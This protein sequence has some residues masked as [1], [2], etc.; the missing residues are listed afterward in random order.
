MRDLIVTGVF[1]IIGVILGGIMSLVTVIYTQ[2][3]TYSKDV[4][5]IKKDTILKKLS[6]VNELIEH[7][8]VNNDEIKEF[9]EYL[10]NTYFKAFSQYDY[11]C[12]MIYLSDDM[13]KIFENIDSYANFIKCNGV[14]NDLEYEL[15][16]HSIKLYKKV[17]V[18]MTQDELHIKPNLLQA[19]L[20][21][22]KV[23]VYYKQESKDL[24]NFL[25]GNDDS[26]LEYEYTFDDEDDLDYKDDL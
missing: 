15:Y 23:D 9:E 18:R 8:P 16:K 26:N 17:L 20:K 24:I 12:A 22:K 1:T 7:L 5:N 6:N 21:D 13:Q 2:N 25:K 3:K 11:A 14:K 4:Q 10:V 19:K